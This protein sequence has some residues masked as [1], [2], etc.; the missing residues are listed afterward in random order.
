MRGTRLGVCVATCVAVLTWTAV[1]A[2]AV[3]PTRGPGGSTS[4]GA[5]PA[6]VACAFAVSINVVAGGQGQ[7]MTFFDRAGNVVRQTDHARPSTWVFTNLDNGKSVTISLPAGILTVST[8]ADG[9]TT[10]VIDGSAIGFN[11]PTDTPPGPFSLTN[12]GRLVIV[13]AADGTGTMTQLSGNTTEL[14]AAVA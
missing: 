14:C 6:G 10:V 8:A 2:G 7:L 13:I 1:P 4:T 12:V 9:T 5:V 3:A 11:A